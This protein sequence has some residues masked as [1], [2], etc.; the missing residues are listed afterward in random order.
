MTTYGYAEGSPLIYSDPEG[1]FVGSILL[2]LGIRY[3]APRLA[4]GAIKR[5]APRVVRGDIKRVVR[6]GPKQPPSC[7]IVEKT[8]EQRAKE[9]HSILDSRAQRARTTAV[10]ETRE[11][12]RVV[13]SSER[14]LTPGQRAQLGA[15]EVEGVG[16]GHA[17]V[18]GIN[19]ARQMGLT[20]TGTAASRP[21][22]PS[23]SNSLRDFGINPLGP[24]K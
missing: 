9:L 10:T 17:E 6:R 13:S 3:L 19:S 21:I 18:T 20:P 1:L 22:C 7:S 12:I 16:L 15:N 11:K 23:C 4:A 2:R 14:R 8:A 24:L 5:V